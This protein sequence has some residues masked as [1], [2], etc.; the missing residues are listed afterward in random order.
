VAPPSRQGFG[1]QLIEFNVAHEFGGNAVLDYR[2]DG[3]RC[4]LAIPL[5]GDTD[6]I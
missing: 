3:V 5:R 6:E 1:S 2:S 4:V